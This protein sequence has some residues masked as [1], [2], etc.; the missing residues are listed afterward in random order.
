MG[1]TPLVEVVFLSFVSSAACT[2]SDHWASRRQPD[3]RAPAAVHARSSTADASPNEPRAGTTEP[4]AQ[5]EESTPL[6]FHVI[7][8]VPNNL[9]LYGA[10]ERGFVTDEA[11]ILLDL[12]GN[13]VRHEARVV[14]E[15]QHDLMYSLNGIVGR[16]PDAVWLSTSHP[17]GRSGYSQLWRWRGS[18]W[19]RERKS[20]EAQFVFDIQPWS[21]GRMLAVLE[22][23]YL[24][25]A[26]FWVLPGVAA[27]RLVPHE[28]GAPEFRRPASPE[29]F[30]QKRTHVEAFA[31]L[32]S[33]HVF[34]AGMHCDS[35]DGPSPGLGVEHWAPGAKQ[36]VYRALPDLP[37]EGA[38][39]GL[40]AL[41]IAALSA[42]DV[43]LA[44]EGNYLAHFDGQ[45]WSRQDCP[46]AGGFIE[47][48]AVEG[49]TVFGLDSSRA[50]WRRRAGEEWQGLPLISSLRK[51][52]LEPGVLREGA[53]LGEAKSVEVRSFWP[54]TATDV[55][56]LAQLNSG[57]SG[58]AAGKRSFLLHTHE[59]TGP[60]PTLDDIDRADRQI[61]VPGP[62]VS[63]CRTPFVLLYTLG[64]NA[65]AD[66][67]Y[68]ATRAALKGHTEFGEAEFIEFARNGRRYFGARVADFELGRKLSELV[69][70][71]VPGSTP[72][73]VCHDPV[74]SRVL[75]IE[76][77]TGKLRQ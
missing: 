64:R 11:K 49:D 46:G 47:L 57:G 16:W 42:S 45:Q 4:R 10:G 41:G 67:D 27:A 77:E 32:P 70:K 75:R 65:P 39:G 63:W 69:G 21:S 76:L 36:P 3:A 54:K 25:D 5:P 48:Y 7:G 50:L 55:W 2:P 24:F 17:W 35:P 40:K 37:A 12:V 31:A 53:H 71:R 1:G 66:Y 18:R 68:P 6:P 60:L 61:S 20:N 8:E 38:Q 58:S 34:V 13:D 29:G 43:Y 28:G 74:G 15:L 9:H 44:A 19:V 56:A 51:A 33:G 62:P 14:P 22:N 73:L 26:A 23:S 72:E 52:A 30:C 59:A